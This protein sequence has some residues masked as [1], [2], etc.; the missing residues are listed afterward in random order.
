M[1]RFARSGELTQLLS[2]LLGQ[3]LDA[4]SRNLW[5]SWHD[6]YLATNLA[7]SNSLNDHLLPGLERGCPQG[8]ADSDS[9]YI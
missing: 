9:I 7:K 6:W 1:A 8:L 3:L 5:I 4:I 2:E